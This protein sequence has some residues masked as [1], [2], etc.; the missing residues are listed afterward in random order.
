MTVNEWE[1]LT[2]FQKEVLDLLRKILH[3]I[4]HPEL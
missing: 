4:E 1:A 3:A 2:P